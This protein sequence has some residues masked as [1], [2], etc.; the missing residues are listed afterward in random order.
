MSDFYLFLLFLVLGIFPTILVL[1]RLYPLEKS[2]RQY[3]L[4]LS[5]TLNDLRARLIRIE[6]KLDKEQKR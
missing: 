4:D 3:F 2:R 6:E 5:N 1:L